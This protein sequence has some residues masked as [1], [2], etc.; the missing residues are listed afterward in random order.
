MSDTPK[1]HVHYW[2]PIEDGGWKCNCGEEKELTLEELKGL[3]EEAVGN[4]DASEYDKGNILY[5]AEEVA[6]KAK[7]DLWFATWAFLNHSYKDVC[8]EWEA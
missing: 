6:D 2:L 7:D 8:E 4:S 5:L 3:L 1:G